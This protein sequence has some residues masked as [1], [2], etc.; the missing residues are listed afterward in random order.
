MIVCSSCGFLFDEANDS[1]PVCASCGGVEFTDEL[2]FRQAVRDT[3]AQ[4]CRST[5]L[6]SLE[7]LK[8]RLQHYPRGIRH[9]WELRQI[10]MQ[11]SS[12]ATGT[13]FMV[14]SNPSCRESWRANRCKHC[15]S[16]VDSRDPDTPRCPRCGW[17]ICAGCDSC[18]CR[19]D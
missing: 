1:Q 14:C 5:P 16:P 17:L 3:L 4:V 9:V 11:C 6:I 8:D 18:N 19:K 12:T 13:T 2:A 10:C 15:K 7:Q